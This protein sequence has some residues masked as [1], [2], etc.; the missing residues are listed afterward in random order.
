MSTLKIIQNIGAIE[1]KDLK[2]RF[3]QFMVGKA[4][5]CAVIAYSSTLSYSA[6]LNIVGSSKIAPYVACFITV[7][8]ALFIAYSVNDMTYRIA[9]WKNLDYR[10]L[11]KGII[12]SAM[13]SIACVCLDIYVNKMGV[14]Q[15]VEATSERTSESTSI[16]RIAVW[17]ADR[18][19]EGSKIYVDKIARNDA[20]IKAIE[21]V[22]K[23]GVTCRCGSW[24]FGQIS[25]AFHYAGVITKYGRKAKDDLEAENTEAMDAISLVESNVE[26]LAKAKRA[27]VNEKIGLEN[28]ER[29]NRKKIHGFGVYALWIA[30][31]F[32]SLVCDI[33]VR[34]FELFMLSNSL[35]KVASTGVN[36]IKK[37]NVESSLL[38]SGLKIKDVADVSELHVNTIKKIRRQLIN[39]GKIAV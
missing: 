32:L 16:D 26:N 37:Y 11:R 34:D 27:E 25:G 6:Y 10:H 1:D 19:K 14:T 2:R 38:A 3:P 36:Y 20:K 22:C 35:Q 7:S 18:I 39:E 4:L 15:L 31:F 23:K 9:Y 13:V 12:F 8:V 29:D 28:S 30:S 33:Y 17:K 5:M 21:N 24:K